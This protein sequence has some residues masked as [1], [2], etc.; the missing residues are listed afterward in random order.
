MRSIQLSATLVVVALSS[1]ANAFWKIGCSQ[2][3][4]V[5]RF[6]NTHCRYVKWYWRNWNYLMNWV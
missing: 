2:P 3:I 6:V 5:E 4:L 1:M